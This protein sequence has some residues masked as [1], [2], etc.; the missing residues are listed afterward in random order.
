MSI[1]LRSKNSANSLIFTISR[2]FGV[3]PLDRNMNPSMGLKMYSYSVA[4]TLSIVG[5]FCISKPR[6]VPFTTFHPF[7]PFV[8][9]A[10]ENLMI[11]ALTTINIISLSK[12]SKVISNIAILQS[13]KPK[14][15]YRPAVIVSAFLF[16]N[17]V[18]HLTD[19]FQRGRISEWPEI[20][21]TWI[22]FTQILLVPLQFCSFLIIIQVRL[23]ALQPSG[24]KETDILIHY[25]L[26]RLLRQL[27]RIY[28]WQ[29]LILV[30]QSFSKVLMS[31]YWFIL[32]G[33]KRSNLRKAAFVVTAL[34]R[35]YELLLIVRWCMA[36]TAAVS[37]NDK[38]EIYF[39]K[40]DFI[41]PEIHLQDRVLEG[42]SKNRVTAWLFW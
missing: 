35:S 8:Y 2:I 14:Q 38:N 11:A 6:E 32:A 34:S 23:A 36:T 24:F 13:A 5:A 28:G 3:F 25:E 18:I 22:Y 21:F 30:I 41:R 40:T 4:V 37:F 31:T 26:L 16:V 12:N 39:T 15:M 1:P 7:F 10:C 19:S 9:A 27:N 17:S 33:N 42:F 29:L 20:F